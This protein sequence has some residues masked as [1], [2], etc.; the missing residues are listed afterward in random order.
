M[1]IIRGRRTVKR[2]TRHAPE[3]RKRAVRLVADDPEEHGSTW[4]TIRLIAGK[5][6]RAA[7]SLRWWVRRAE[8]DTAPSFGPNDDGPAAA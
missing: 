2:R 1:R 6:E 5:M 7:K 8:P 4:P 3:N